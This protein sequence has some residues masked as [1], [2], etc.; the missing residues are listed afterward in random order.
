MKATIKQAEKNKRNLTIAF[1]SYG[2]W[3]IECDYRNK[4][5]H[6]ITTN[7]MAVDDFKSDF[8]ETNDDGINRRKH[9]YEILINEIIRE[10]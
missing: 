9:G 7:S 10:N 3:E 2:N 4:R 5:I 6:A 1:K 8:G